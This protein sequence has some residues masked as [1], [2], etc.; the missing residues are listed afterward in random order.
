MICSWVL[1]F[2]TTCS[3]GSPAFKLMHTAATLTENQVMDSL[4]DLTQDDFKK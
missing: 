1:Y 4:G 3:R 2:F